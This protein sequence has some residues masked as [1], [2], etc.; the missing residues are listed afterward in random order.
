MS[1]ICVAVE[2]D[3]LHR[4]IIERIVSA[5]DFVV[6]LAQNGKDGLSL[7]DV[8]NPD[9]IILDWMMPHMSGLEFMDEI[10]SKEWRSDCKAILCTARGQWEAE[11]EAEMHNIDIVLPKPFYP[12]ELVEK[13][14]EVME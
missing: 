6:Y 13:I 9:L 11:D 3:E 10:E 1:K 8:H 7:C 14:N 12:Y 5:M 4:V 2:D